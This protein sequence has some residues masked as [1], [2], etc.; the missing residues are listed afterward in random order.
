MKF[1]EYNLCRIRE[2]NRKPILENKTYVLYWMQA[3]RRFTSNHAL[4]Y[5][6]Y[7]SY[8]L[9]K[10]L[11][12]YEGLR[13]DYRWNSKRTHS[14][15]LEGMKDNQTYAKKNNLNYW[16]F[17]ET[18]E[19][20]AKGILKKISANACVIV[21]DDFPSFI[22][23]QQNESLANKIE[24][25]M[26]V[27]DSNSIIPICKYGEHASASRVLRPRI[28]K[29]FA[30]AYQ[31]KAREKLTSK[32]LFKY[33]VNSKAPFEIIDLNEVSSQSILKKIKF[34]NQVS[35]VNIEGGSIQANKQLKFF[36]QKNLSRYKTERS[37]PHSPEIT[38][39]SALSP[40]LHFGHISA[41]TI[42]TEILNH[43][44]EKKWAIESLNID[45]K[46]DKDL[47]FHNDINI[48]SYFDELL[49][50][51]DIG[52]LLFWQKKE[53]NKNLNILPDWIKK[54]LSKHSIDKREYLYSK[55]EFRASKTHDPI[56]N[57]AQ[58]ELILT[59]KMHNYMRMLW[60]KK[61]IEWTKTY[62]EAF[63]I[64]EDFNNLYAL[65]G[66][67]PN[68]YTGILWCFGLFDRPWFP[69]RNVHGV[70]RYMSSDSTRKKFKL[71]EYLD[72]ISKLENKSD[73][74]F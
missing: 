72:Y 11:V 38:P 3:Y 25:K 23:P 22:I 52:Y 64:M 14:F 21:S 26:V 51:R 28:H 12:I 48:N 31:N 35:K 68:S 27:V 62:E 24:C 32:D 37:N 66:R 7:L 63:D 69:E 57:A 36:I 9:K 33:E 49:T 55:E 19:Q 61:I 56:W 29:N 70:L 71:Q 8:K 39:G 5:A 73:S 58:S 1:S 4:D 45:S 2:L 18:N 6:L 74:L 43:D 34:Q 67:N 20:P 60:G 40:Y 30:E 65:D 15:I 54:N 10:E 41:E 53:F 44:S 16:S 13:S 50:W 59:G 17:I 47:F 46:G 42:V